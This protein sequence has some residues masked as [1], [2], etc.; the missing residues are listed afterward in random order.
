MCLNHFEHI[1]EICKSSKKPSNN[2]KHHQYTLFYKYTLEEIFTIASRLKK[3]VDAYNKWCL[4]VESIVEPSLVKID[5]DSDESVVLVQ[6]EKQTTGG[7]KKPNISRLRELL[8]EAVSSKYPR[9]VTSRPTLHKANARPRALDGECLFNALENELEEAVRVQTLCLQIKDA[10]KANK[11]KMGIVDIGHVDAKPRG[12][13][14]LDSL[15][16][17]HLKET[18]GCMNRL[19]CELDYPTKEM[20]S[21]IYNEA[22]EQEKLIH[23]LIIEWN[24]SDAAKLERSLSYMSQVRFADDIV[25]DLELMKKQATW[26]RD[27]DVAGE[28]PSSLTLDVLKSLC[29][30]VKSEYLLGGTTSKSKE[31]VQQRFEELDELLTIAQAWDNRARKAIDSK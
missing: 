10:Y 11:N 21:F 6:D 26:L 18:Y 23:Q 1:K 4:A 3:R 5:Y 25:E 16:L 30:R 8:H 13:K 15:S 7:R 29:G 20:I 12:L 14:K 17:W 2:A 9:F 24:L 22:L 31:V 28:D 19:C 27:V